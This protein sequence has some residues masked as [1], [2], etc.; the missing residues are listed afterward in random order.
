M[1]HRAAHGLGGFLLPLLIWTVFPGFDSLASQREGNLQERLRHRISVVWKGQ[2][3]R[4]ALAGLSEREQLCVWIDRRVD[5]EQTIELVLR[6]VSLARAFEELAASRGLH[7]AYL[8][9]VVYLGPDDAAEE[10]MALCE[11]LRATLTHSP[12]TLRSF[13]FRKSAWTWPRLSEPRMLLKD[14]FSDTPIELRDAE[15][16]PHDL[17][18]AKQ[19]PRMTRIDR[20]T[21]LLIG[22]HL[23]FQTDRS[24]RQCRIVPIESPVVITRQYGFRANQMP[25]LARLKHRF[26][27][28]NMELREAGSTRATLKVT[29]P[30]TSQQKFRSVLKGRPKSPHELGSSRSGQ[31]MPRERQV[32]NLEIRGQ[33]VRSVLRQLAA[34][35]PVELIWDERELSATGHSL[36]ARISCKV[37]SASLEQLLDAVLTPAG[38]R[39]QRV[40]RQIRIHSSSKNGR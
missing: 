21:L 29:G 28:L 32:Y 17:W 35:L 2:T 6:N 16:I 7:V 38:L 1:Q 27:D 15:R 5:P 11:K 31:P 23:T 33:T 39:Y 12:G 26:P 3:L 22:F 36:D 30:W 9:S 40:G 4:N 19:L 37:Q 10:I 8:E 34:Q 18:D 14:L 20:A 24:G 13:W 25:K